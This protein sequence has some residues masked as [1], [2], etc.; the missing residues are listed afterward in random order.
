MAA[1]M[2]DHLEEEEA[3]LDGEKIIDWLDVPPSLMT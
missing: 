3:D 1:R 2:Q